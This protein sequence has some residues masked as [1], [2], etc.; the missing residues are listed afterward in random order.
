VTSEASTSRQSLPAE[1][2]EAEFPGQV[3]DE[4]VLEQKKV[5]ECEQHPA[6]GNKRETDSEPPHRVSLSR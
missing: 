6:P 5:R 3:P 1:S 4:A 2:P